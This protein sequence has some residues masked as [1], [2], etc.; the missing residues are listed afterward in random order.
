MVDRHEGTLAAPR[1]LLELDSS[2]ERLER[3]LGLLQ[4]ELEILQAEL[5]QCP[6]ETGVELDV[7]QL[8][9]ANAPIAERVCPSSSW[10]LFAI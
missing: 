1:L 4:A 10:K 3:L 7:T 9:A 6:P 5:E 2:G 8:W